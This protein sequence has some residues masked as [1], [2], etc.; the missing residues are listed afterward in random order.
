[1]DESIRDEHQGL[2][3]SMGAEDIDETFA[4]VND[5][6]NARAFHIMDKFKRLGSPEIN[7]SLEVLKKF[8]R[9]VRDAEK[10]LFPRCKKFSKLEVT[11]HLP[12]MKCLCG[13][14]DKSLTMILELLKK[15][16]D[17]D[18]TFPKNACEVKKYAHDLGLGYVKIE[19]CKNNCILY[20]KEY[21]HADKCPKCSHPRWKNKRE[22]ADDSDDESD[23]KGQR[24][25]IPYKILHYFPLILRLQRLFMFA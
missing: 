23:K 8:A 20:W 7:E 16:F 5:T 12:H 22:E 15:A 19:A 24:K 4:M 11:A 14:S 2:M 21:E 17:F 1:M 13:L 18:D 6:T 3:L 25:S 10:E 9:L